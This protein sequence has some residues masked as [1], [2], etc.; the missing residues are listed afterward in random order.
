METFQLVEEAIQLVSKLSNTFSA[1]GATILFFFFFFLSFLFFLLS[2]SLS[3]FK[4]LT[5]PGLV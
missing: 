2:L 1:T 5:H 3:L 4:S